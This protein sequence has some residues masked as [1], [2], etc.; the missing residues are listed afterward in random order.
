MILT[1]QRVPDEQQ[2]S[3]RRKTEVWGRHELQSPSCLSI[4]EERT[5]VFR[6]RFLP[7]F[8]VYVSIVGFM[9]SKLICE[10]DCAK[11]ESLTVIAG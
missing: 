2:G 4:A 7:V 9:F 6:N 8:Y 10:K 1:P 3:P 5:H 11:Q